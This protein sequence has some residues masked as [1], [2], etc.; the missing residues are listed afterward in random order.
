MD[1]L[2]RTTWVIAEGYIPPDST[3]DERAFTGIAF[4]T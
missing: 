4:P 2:G 1:H 3:G